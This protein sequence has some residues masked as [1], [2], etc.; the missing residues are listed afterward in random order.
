V[1]LEVARPQQCF[2]QRQMSAASPRQCAA[3]TPTSKKST[4]C[5]S[6]LL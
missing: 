2:Y 1:I 5:S 3:K 6:P 4:A